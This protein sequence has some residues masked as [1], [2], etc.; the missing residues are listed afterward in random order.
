M[1][2]EIFQVGRISVVILIR[3]DTTLDHSQE[4]EKVWT[5]DTRRHALHAPK[6]N[7]SVITRTPHLFQNTCHP[8]LFTRDGLQA[9]YRWGNPRKNFT[10]R[11]N[12]PS[13]RQPLVKGERL[14]RSELG[15]AM[16]MSSAPPITSND[17][18]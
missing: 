11:K 2:V 12:A 10:I 13:S 6:V 1:T 8:K 15:A 9:T 5:R 14:V 7:D 4:A 16:G 3:T 17:I 18:L